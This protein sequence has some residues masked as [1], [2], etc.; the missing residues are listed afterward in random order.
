MTTLQANDEDY[1][2]LHQGDELLVTLNGYPPD[3]LVQAWQVVAT[4]YY[5][6]LQN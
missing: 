2:V 6:Q 3:G 5:I 1:V 4:G